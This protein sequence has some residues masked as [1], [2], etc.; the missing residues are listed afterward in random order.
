MVVFGA[1]NNC[2]RAAAM[3]PSGFM[4][5]SDPRLFM[6]ASYNTRDSVN[7]PYLG[8][9]DGFFVKLRTANVTGVLDHGIRFGHFLSTRRSEQTLQRTV[10]A[11]AGGTLH[12]R[13]DRGTFA[14]NR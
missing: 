12:V 5:S 10:A 7:E 9:H 4:I 2:V 3:G 1:W 11:T 13:I 6:L 8:G 14:L